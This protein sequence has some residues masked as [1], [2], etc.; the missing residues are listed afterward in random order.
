ML[1][2]GEIAA[3]SCIFLLP[4]ICICEKKVKTT[5]ADGLIFCLIIN[6]SLFFQIRKRWVQIQGGADIFLPAL[7][8]RICKGRKIQANEVDG[9][10]FCEF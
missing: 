7:Y 2:A 4:Y 8:T 9:P 5:H 1:G 3:T 10:I 6:T